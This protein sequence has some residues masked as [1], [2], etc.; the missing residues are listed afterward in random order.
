MDDARNELDE[1]MMESVK[2]AVSDADALLAIVDATKNPVNELAMIKPG[3]EWSGPPL[4][5]LL[6]KIDALGGTGSGSGGGEKVEELVQWYRDN[7]GCSTTNNN[8][9][10]NSDDSDSDRITVIAISALERQGLDQV[11]RWVEKHLPLGQSLYP[12][13]FVSEASERFF[14]SEILRKHIFLHY[15]QEIPYSV[16]V[17]VADFKERKGNKCYISVNIFVEHDRQKG[18]IIGKGGLALK[19]LASEARV[20]IE[21]FLGRKVYMEVKVKVAEGWRKDPQQLERLG[22][23]HK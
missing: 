13:E 6:N 15:Q 1:R 4:A 18:I 21:E 17:E 22:Y 9:N 14:V 20:E 8:N 3:K 16:A 7:A 19:N 11:S 23:H 2:V 5:I 12:K 10:N